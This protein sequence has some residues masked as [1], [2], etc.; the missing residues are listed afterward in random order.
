MLPTDRRRKSGD[1]GDCA[2]LARAGPSSVLL[3]TAIAMLGSPG[4]AESVAALGGGGAGEEIS[5]RRQARSGPPGRRSVDDRGPGAGE[6]LGIAGMALASSTAA[7][8]RGVPWSVPWNVQPKQ[9]MAHK[10]L[11]A[12]ELSLGDYERGLAHLRSAADLDPTDSR[13]WIA[14]GKAY[15]DLGQDQES[16]DSYQA[17]YHRDPHSREAPA[18]ARRRRPE[19]QSPRP[20]DAASGPGLA[21]PPRTPGS[22]AWPCATRRPWAIPSRRPASRGVPLALDPD[23]FDALVARATFRLASRASR[24]A[25]AKTWSGPSSSTRSVSRR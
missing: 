7:P 4:P 11:A 12:I 5:Q 2:S 17:A 24:R 8:S 21:G 23:N 13:P 6:A 14:M 19:D 18:R 15:H 20:G 9:P 3:A 10:V 16:A 25:P 1:G 22:W